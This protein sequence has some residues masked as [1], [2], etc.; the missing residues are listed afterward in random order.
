MADK[1]ICLGEE[2][3]E[4][5][6]YS[7]FG[8][9]YV[10]IMKDDEVAKIT[11]FK[12][13][14]RDFCRTISINDETFK[15][16]KKAARNASPDQNVGFAIDVFNGEHG[17]NKLTDLLDDILK[18]DSKDNFN[19]IH[20]DICEHIIRI[21]LEVPYLEKKDSNEEK[22]YLGQAQKWLNMTLKY[23][24]LTRVWDNEFSEMQGFLDIPLDSYILKSVFYKKT[25]DEIK[26]DPE[27]GD[28]FSTYADQ[29]NFANSDG[30]LKYSDIGLHGE[31]PKDDNRRIKPIPWSKIKDYNDYRKI[32][33]E[34]RECM[35]DE[36]KQDGKCPLEWENKVWL[37]AAKK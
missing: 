35:R 16:Y 15:K 5:L 28:L 25:R 34:L 4:F 10:D 11:C 18:T 36:Y 31:Y 20:K 32:Q 12:R 24:Y 33:D 19:S 2:A 22:F 30:S 13:A 21:A 37:V 3:Q 8:E 27:A 14:Y 6:F 7:Y 9:N 23:M 1:K 17:G 29:C 26:K